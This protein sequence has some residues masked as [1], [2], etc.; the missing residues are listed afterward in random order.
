MFLSVIATY[1]R[2]HGS[3]RSPGLKIRLS[4]EGMGSRSTV[5]IRSSLASGCYL[6]STTKTPQGA[7]TD[8]VPSKLRPS[9]LM[10]PV[11]PRRFRV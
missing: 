11:K 8:V 5:G 4:Q 7:S 6:P 3:G 1:F 2:Y 9:W 10:T